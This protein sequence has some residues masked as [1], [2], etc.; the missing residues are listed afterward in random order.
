MNLRSLTVLVFG[1]FALCLSL[2]LASAQ[3]Q[4]SGGQSSSASPGLTNSSPYAL[5]SLGSGYSQNS[6]NSY[7]NNPFMGQAAA[8]EQYHQNM[9]QYGILRAQASGIMVRNQMA[10]AKSQRKQIDKASAELRKQREKERAEAVAVREERLAARV[11]G[12]ERGS[13]STRLTSTN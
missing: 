8:A 7:S 6:L 11:K 5:N 1:S 10:E 2:P 3:C 12:E 4:R 9:R 13:Q